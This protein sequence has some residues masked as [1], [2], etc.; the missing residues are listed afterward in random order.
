M[1]LFRDY[2][3]CSSIVRSVWVYLR[4]VWSEDDEPS[5]HSC[6]SSA[7]LIACDHTSFSFR[8]YCF[9]TEARLT[10][11]CCNKY[12]HYWQPYNLTHTQHWLNEGSTSWMS[13]LLILNAYPTAWMH[14]LQLECIPY[15]LNS[16]PTAWMHSLQ[17]EC[18]PYSLNAYPTDFE[19]IP[20]W[21]WMHTLL[22]LNAYPTDFECIP[23]NLNAYPT[24]WMHNLQLEC[25]SSNDPPNLDLSFRHFCTTHMVD[26]FVPFAYA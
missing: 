9:D 1:S 11:Q 17:L 18:I 22:I 3:Y 2:F 16:Y 15:S 5:M 14:T 24:T 25:I 4:V 23:Y 19:C 12:L 8:L 13:T 21:F 10:S 6:G 20:Y 7:S 26:L